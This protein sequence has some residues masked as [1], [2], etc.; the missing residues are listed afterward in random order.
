LVSLKSGY[1]YPRLT[2]GSPFLTPSSPYH[3]IV[4][5]T[6]RGTG[7]GPD[8]RWPISGPY[9]QGKTVIPESGFVTSVFTLSFKFL[10]CGRYTCLLRNWSFPSYKRQLNSSSTTYLPHDCSFLGAGEIKRQFDPPYYI[11]YKSSLSRVSLMSALL[12]VPYRALPALTLL[13]TLS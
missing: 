1:P 6:R 5:F 8:A 12:L 2:L 9:L 4:N 13:L 10:R 3:K 7:F 11:P